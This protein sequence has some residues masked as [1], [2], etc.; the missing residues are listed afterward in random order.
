M[1]KNGKRSFVIAL[2]LLMMYDPT[3][4]LGLDTCEVINS[5]EVLL[6]HSEVMVGVEWD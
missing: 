5:Q 3:I 1:Q 4:G 2:L 6:I